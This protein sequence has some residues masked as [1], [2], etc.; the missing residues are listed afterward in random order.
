MVENFKK[1]DAVF[2]GSGGCDLCAINLKRFW[3]QYACDPNQGNFSK[4][5]YHKLRWETGFGCLPMTNLE[6]RFMF[7]KFT[8]QWRARQPASFLSLVSE[9]PTHPN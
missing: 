3:C 8:L 5:N 7:N 6:W 1:I 2:G 9:P 4:V